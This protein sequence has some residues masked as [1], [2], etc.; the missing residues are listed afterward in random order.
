MGGKLVVV[1]RAHTCGSGN[2]TE[3]GRGKNVQGQRQNV[4]VLDEDVGKAKRS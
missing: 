4:K 1:G 3:R 2:G